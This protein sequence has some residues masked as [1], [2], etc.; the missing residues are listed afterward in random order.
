[1]RLLA[2]IV[3]VCFVLF[4]LGILVAMAYLGTRQD[5]VIVTRPRDWRM[6]FGGIP[7]GL[8]ICAAGVYLWRVDID[9]SEDQ[10]T[11]TPFAE[12]LIAHRREM[13]LFAWIGFTFSA[14]R[15]VAAFFGTDWPGW[16]V[17]WPLAIGIGV[18]LYGSRN[19][20][21]YFAT[22]RKWPRL[23]KIRTEGAFLMFCFLAFCVVQRYRCSRIRA[24]SDR[25]LL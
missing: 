24:L 4:G 2:R 8:A 25:R 23:I 17:D 5:S 3:A 18:L 1:M 16:W 19:A 22:M 12:F 6:V 10:Q 21:K 14:I 13:T 20:V 9:A 15:S 11:T 7:V